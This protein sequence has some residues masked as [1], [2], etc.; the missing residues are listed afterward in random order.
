MTLGV[1]GYLP[2][3]DTGG[4]RVSTRVWVY[5]LSSIYPGMPLGVSG[6]LPRYEYWGTRVSTGCDH[7]NAG[8]SVPS[9]I[10]TLLNAP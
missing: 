9:T 2:G 5:G 10:Y 8:Y 3:Y 7:N 4:D 1:P 6:Y